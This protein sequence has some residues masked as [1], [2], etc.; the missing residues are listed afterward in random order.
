MD[1]DYNNHIHL[2]TYIGREDL[3]LE[4]NG[5]Y[6][7]YENHFKSELVSNLEDSYTIYFN[8]KEILDPTSKFLI[9]GRL[10]VCQ[11][12]KYTYANGHQDPVVE[13]IFYPYI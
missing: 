9:H 13:G 2:P 1:E 5:E 11:Q 10:F 12:L 7:L 4:L 8:S 3:T 6:G